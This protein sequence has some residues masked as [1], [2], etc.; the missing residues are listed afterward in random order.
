MTITK[1]ID[2]SLNKLLDRFPSSILEYQYKDIS[3]T[4]FIKISPKR[5]FQEED[6]I[7]I[8]FELSDKFSELFPDSS[9]CFLT[10]DSIIKLDNPSIKKSVNPYKFVF[11]LQNQSK[12]VLFGNSTHVKQNSLPVIEFKNNCGNRQVAMAA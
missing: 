8:D 4:H 1:F 5:Y 3:D 6:F 12:V 7:D 10:D 2:D 9:L 11:D